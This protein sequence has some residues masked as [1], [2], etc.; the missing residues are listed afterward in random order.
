MSECADIA[1]RRNQEYVGTNRFDFSEGFLVIKAKH[2]GLEVWRRVV[3]VEPDSPSV[4]SRGRLVITPLQYPSVSA[5]RDFQL[6]AAALAPVDKQTS[7]GQFLPHAYIDTGDVGAVRLFRIKFPL[8]AYIGFN[9][10][11]KVTVVDAGS[12]E[13]L[14]NVTLGEGRLLGMP[15]R[16]FFPLPNDRV[17]MD[18]DISKE[19]ICVC[20][21]TVLIVLRL[22]KHCTSDHPHS[23]ANE[24]ESGPPDMLVLGE[25]DS[26]AARQT[27]ACLLTPVV[28]DTDVM[29]WSS[30]N[31]SSPVVATMS[32]RDAF[33][34]FQV[35]PPS[36]A[37]QRANMHALVPLN[38]PTM[39]A[40]FVSGMYRMDEVC[41]S[42]SLTLTG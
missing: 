4:F 21:Y 20:M 24:V 34:R 1:Q 38:G 16:F 13:T 11:N 14:W 5:I 31:H 28:E 19:H 9:N 33:E 15:P 27:N 18:L 25:L 3:D 2:S 26:P 39:R 23:V 40:G 17:P 35:T 36:E 7:R 41:V 12:G 32:G 8:L 37:V 42:L 10:S 30:T 29:T 22:P 6:Q